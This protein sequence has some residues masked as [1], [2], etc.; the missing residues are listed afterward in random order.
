MGSLLQE[1]LAEVK[2]M[3]LNYTNGKIQTAEFYSGKMYNL[4]LSGTNCR[5]G[6][7]LYD[8]EENLEFNRLNDGVL[9]IVQ[10]DGNTIASYKY[11][12]LFEG[13]VEYTT[14]NAKTKK[15]NRKV[16]FKIRENEYGVGL[17]YQDNLGTTLDFNNLDEIRRHLRDSFPNHKPI[18]WSLYI[19]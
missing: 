5:Q 4:F 2:C 17:N 3:I 12:T 6:M 14:L 8:S 16:T 1:R 9:I 13:V 10:K 18:D 15:V 19:G 7:G 11:M